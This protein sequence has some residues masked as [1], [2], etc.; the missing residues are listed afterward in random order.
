MTRAT[1]QDAVL[2]A[3]RE[4]ILTGVLAPGDQLVQEALAERYGVSRVPLREALKML[5]SEGQVVNHPHRG[6][7]VAELSVADLREV[8]H[9]RALLEHAALAAAIP[10]LEDDDVTEIASLCV[11]VDEAAIE[12]D[13]IAM[14]EANRRFHFA[15]YDA[16][17]M[18]RL[19]RLL[20][21]LWDATDAY[22]ALYYQGSGN[23][24]RVQSE[25][26]A[27]LDAL[28]SRDAEA[29]IALHDDHRAHSVAAVESMLT[30]SDRR[31]IR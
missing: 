28:R 10:M 6:Y 22:R 24:S 17:G 25:H 20:R 7:F 18:P 2:A 1:A 16:A 27:M 23:R 3:L 4:D 15:M 29:V 11:D 13:V 9:L 26:A 14:A 5:E 19:S 31:H 30:A 8:Y 21:Q 12:G